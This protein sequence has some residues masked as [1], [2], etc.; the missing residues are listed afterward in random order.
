[1]FR[2]IKIISTLECVQDWLSVKTGMGKRGTEWGNDRNAGNQGG[3]AENHGGNAGNQGRNV[4]NQGG[5]AGNQGRNAGNQGGN[6][7]NQSDSL[8]KS[9]CL[10]LRLKS[11]IARG[12]FHHPAFMGNCET[13]GHT[14]YS[15]IYPVDEGNED[16]G[17]V[18]D[19]ILLFLL[20]SYPLY[21]SILN[22][23]VFYCNFLTQ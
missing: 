8:W 22:R 1:M 17:L 14:I 7:G 19:N 2:I 6:A 21:L 13:I 5:N 18:W 12:A 23:F 4:G 11:W 10:L 9:S 3:N 15:P 20:N 16:V